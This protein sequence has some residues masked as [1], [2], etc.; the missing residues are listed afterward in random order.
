MT[1]KHGSRV[2]F[3]ANGGCSISGVGIV[4]ERTAYR[5]ACTGEICDPARWQYT[6]RVYG[7][8]DTY[9]EVRADEE[10]VFWEK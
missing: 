4:H 8:L 9:I 7:P 2:R 3:T 10:S 5:D 1:P 6:I